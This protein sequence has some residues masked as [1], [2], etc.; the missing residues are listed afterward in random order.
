M[1]LTQLN[2]TFH[3]L[4][5]LIFSR[6]QQIKKRLL[7][8]KNGILNDISCT[9]QKRIWL[10]GGVTSTELLRLHGAIYSQLTCKQLS[11]FPLK[12][13]KKT[14]FTNHIKMTAI[15]KCQFKQLVSRQF[16]YHIK[17][18]AYQKQLHWNGILNEIYFYKV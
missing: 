8:K 13:K 10:A 1:Q 5:S 6:Y 7:T 11:S 18:K 9:L 17:T 15:K 2:K 12:K 16:R 3:P 4:A 14:V